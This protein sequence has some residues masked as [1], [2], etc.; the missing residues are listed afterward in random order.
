MTTFARRAA[1]GGCWVVALALFAVYCG[2]RS[3]GEQER[4]AA[5]ARF[6]FNPPPIAAELTL[7][8]PTDGPPDALN[9][10]NP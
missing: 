3:Y 1:N 2:L 6:F 8:E 10:R 9:A 7:V 4:Q 5:I